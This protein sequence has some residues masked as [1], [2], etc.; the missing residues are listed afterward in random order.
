MT[1]NFNG[2]LFPVKDIAKV[3]NSYVY[4][5]R[6]TAITFFEGLFRK[7]MNEDLSVL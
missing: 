7:V 4:A 6:L 3:G 2:F 1:L 5:F